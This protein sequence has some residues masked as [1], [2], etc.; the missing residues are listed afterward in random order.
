MSPAPRP[1][2]SEKSSSAGHR[3]HNQGKCDWGRIS[4]L[5]PLTAKNEKNNRKSDDWTE[6]NKALQCP[7]LF[8]A[9]QCLFIH[10]GPGEM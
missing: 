7:D 3:T 1:D 10:R 4:R 8:H 6:V 5:A 2:D 9:A